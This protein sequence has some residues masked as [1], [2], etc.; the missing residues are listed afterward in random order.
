MDKNTQ[1]EDKSGSK[2][3]SGMPTV[4]HGNTSVGPGAQ[5][6]PYKLLRILGEGGYGIVYL[7]E[8]QQPMKR[9][10]AL[11]LIKPGM[12]TK[13]VIARFEAE[14]QALALLD[15]PNIAHVFN[16]GTSEAG[17]P[18][19]AMEYVKGVPITEHCDRYKLTIEERLKL[20]LLVCEAV[21]HAHQKAI[22]HRDIKPSNI[23][24]AYEAEQAVPMIID[25]GV[26]KALSQPLTERTLVTEHA[27]MVGTPEYMSPEQAEMTSQD[28]DTRT[29]IYSLG[30]LLY[31]LLTGTLPFDP[32][33]LR[34]GGAEKMRR[35]IREQDPQTPSA[36]LGTIENETSLSLAEQ[37]R[38][39]IRTL[40]HRLH[41]ELDWITLKAMDKDRTHRYQTAHAFAE[42]I[43]RYLNQEP[44]LASPPSATYKL[45][46]LVNRNK[47]LFASAA[48]IAVVVVL[49]LI[50][51]IHQAW[52]AHRAKQ[53]EI[54]ARSAVE[55]ERDRAQEAERQAEKKYRDEVF[56][57]LSQAHDLEVPGK[58]VVDLRSEAIAC[59]GDYVGLEPTALLELPDAPNTPEIEWS[60]LHPTDSVA[61]FAL[62]D[63][64][65]VLKDLDSTEDI[66]R[67]DCEHRP[68]GL[69]FSSTGDTL[70]S[71]HRPK[72]DSTD[73]RPDPVAHLFAYSQDNAWV[74]REIVEIPNAVVCTSTTTGF[75]IITVDRASDSASLSE[76][77]TDGIVRKLD[78]TVDVNNATGGDTSADGR[79]MA[80]ATTEPANS[81]TSVVYVWDISQ[82]QRLTR[83]EPNLAKCNYLKFSPD[84]RYL[85]YSSDSGAV[86]Y[87]AE[88]WNPVGRLSQ[89]FGGGYSAIFLPNSTVLVFS[90]G[91]RFYLW[92]F[93]R[94][95]YLAI[96]RQL[97]KG[98]EWFS[99]SAD[100]K[101]LVTHDDK[102]AWLYKLDAGSP[103]I[104]WQRLRT[105]GLE[106]Y[107]R[108]VGVGAT[109]GSA[110]P[111]HCIQ[112]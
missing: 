4:G 45:R 21:Q 38:T 81:N 106:R 26:A 20:F 13:Q 85:A 63:G 32:Q 101:S 15:H 93:K 77:L 48:T 40:G 97:L 7:A 110:R 30:V 50:V 17:R 12:D 37:R 55:A 70:L 16:A 51:S 82:N 8:Q 24:I 78:F 19:F 5:I 14:R 99:V 46:K 59:L 68:W 94:N 42:D 41:G 1:S 90:R 54:S 35:M 3:P 22:I 11:K 47:A 67:F 53:A 75:M 109:T 74:Q 111:K 6:G 86:I 89:G 107:Y 58:D 80:I 103:C 83:L 84:G 87:S 73:Q 95:E 72:R 104:C 56:Q 10:V 66:A 52:V 44:V 9:R 79:L 69:C 105:S 100:G 62:K 76:L 29:D 36:R 96:F 27:Q 28:I 91:S 102:R 49:A 23:L 92:D 34:E 39:D 112:F 65:V 25:F 18:Y 2:D 88:T 98:I 43:Q 71:L 61:A 60:Q 108:P 33:T 31:E 57:A 64:T